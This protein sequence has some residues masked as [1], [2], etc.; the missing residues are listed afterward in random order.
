MT[1]YLNVFIIWLKDNYYFHFTLLTSI[2]DIV[3]CAFSTAA[4]YPS[5]HGMVEYMH[6]NQ[7]K[8]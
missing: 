2:Q 4:I 8:L 5:Y 6:M 1:H 7:C 3:N